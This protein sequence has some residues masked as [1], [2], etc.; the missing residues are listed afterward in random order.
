MVEKLFEPIKVNSVTSKNRIVFAPT[1]MGTSAPDGS[2]TDQTLCHY[3]A[4]AKGGAGWI[5]VE[6]TFC[7][8]KYG[9]GVL[10]FHS[11]RQLRGMRDLA[12]AIHAFGAVAIVQV[13]LGAGR[14][15]NPAR[16][17]HALVAPSPQPYRIEAG[18]APRGLRWMEGATGLVPRE[19][20]TAEV[21]ELEGLFVE[22]ALRIKEAGF[23]GMEIHGAHGYLLAQFVSPLSNHRTDKY[24]G[25]LEHRLTLP[26]NLIR[27]ARDRLG[28]QFVLG[29]RIS[30]DEHVRGGLTLQETRR[31]LPI[32]VAEGLDF[33][34]LS[35]GRMEALNYLF[36][37]EEGVVLPEAKAIKEVVDIPVI[38]PNI[39]TPSLAA[40]V[41]EE[42]WSD[43]VSL[44]RSLI[45]DPEWP[46]K[47]REGR[48]HEINKCIRCNTCIKSLWHL[49]GTRCAVNP[50]VGK[51]RFMPQYYPPLTKIS[52]TM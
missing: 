43:M 6:H 19:L 39:H 29:Y 44:C 8:A 18:T 12:D 27:K 34:H 16:T 4:R 3:V 31:I 22:S 35:S 7:T 37:E 15:G 51:E 2:V 1:G 25:P 52:E 14:Q 38:C 36:P 41:V 47:V 13:G 20:T 33:V 42:G 46:N 10:C 50:A 49:I 32:L 28:S 48:E 45:A 26:R 23:D 40:R 21:E 5:T 9:T 11:D 24:G 17:G 30:G